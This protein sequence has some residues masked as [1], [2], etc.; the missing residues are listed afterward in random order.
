MLSALV[1]YD[2]SVSLDGNLKRLLEGELSKNKTELIKNRKYFYPLAEPSYGVEEV[3]EAIDSMVTF[4]TSMWNKVR[5]FEDMFGRKYGGHAIMVNSGSS[6]DLLISFALLKKSGGNLQPGDEILV[7]AVTWPTHLWSLVMAGLQVRLIDIDLTT[8]NFD[9]E[10][11]KDQIST[12]TKGIFIVHLLG[13]TGNLEVL[14]ELC[15]ENDLVLLEDCCEAL[16][17][18]YQ[19]KYVGTF[20]LASSFSFFFSHH[21]VTM[22]GGMILTKSEEFANRCKLLRA[23]GWTRNLQSLAGDDRAAFEDK[24]KFVN[25]GFNVRPTELQ[26]GFGLRQLEK[27]ED[28]HEARKLNAEYLTSRLQRH[29]AYISTIIPSDKVESSYFAFPIIINSRSSVSRR[30]FS[31]FLEKSGVETRPIV[32]GNLARQ[33]ATT[34]FAEISFG[35]LSSSDYVHEFGLY[36]GIHPEFNVAKIEKVANIIDHFF[37]NR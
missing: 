9:I 17:T 31:T 16:G 36:I 10:K 14:Q 28:F 35:D 7:P 19:N 6:A 23:H 30:E 3:L 8:L 11:L 21:L 1:C 33:P 12:K 26:A 25:W 13:N 24:Y 22:E 15:T 4:K 18:K 20:G 32:A 5:E 37:E 29:R 34:S 2:M 27:V